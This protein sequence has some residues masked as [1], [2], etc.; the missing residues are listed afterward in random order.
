MIRS[1]SRQHQPSRILLDAHNSAAIR[2]SIAAVKGNPSFSSFRA[3]RR[4]RSASRGPV[5]L[6]NDRRRNGFLID[7]KALLEIGT[8]IG[9]LYSLCPRHRSSKTAPPRQSGGIPCPHI[10]RLTIVVVYG[11]PRE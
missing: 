2:H 3:L 4:K 10:A 1:H 5:I 9:E 11:N 7:F 8:E 6:D